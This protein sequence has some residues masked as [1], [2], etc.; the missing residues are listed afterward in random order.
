MGECAAKMA[1]K[2]IE[3]KTTSK[4]LTVILPTTVVLRDSTSCALVSGRAG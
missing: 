1:L 4:R 3:S 2:P